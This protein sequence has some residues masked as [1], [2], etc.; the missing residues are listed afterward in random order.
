MKAPAVFNALL[1]LSALTALGPSCAA[2]PAILLEACN[3]MEPARK[4]LECLR[5]ANDLSRGTFDTS[6]SS[7]G[8]APQSLYSPIQ[9]ARG[10]LG[11]SQLRGRRPHLL[12]RASR[13]YLHDHRERAQKLQRML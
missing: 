2:T 10:P 3:A 13:R 7:A 6:S 12:R 11:G 5:V 4:R 9:A 8:A 1:A